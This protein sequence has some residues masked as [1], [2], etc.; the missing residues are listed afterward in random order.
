[1]TARRLNLKISRKLLLAF[2]VV[3]ATVGISNTVVFMANQSVDAATLEAKLSNDQL[4]LEAGVLASAVDVQNSMRGFI[5]S[6]DAKSFLDAKV[7]FY[8]KLKTLDTAYQSLADMATDEDDRA[9]LAPVHD[10]IETFKSEADAAIQMG[11]N[12]ETLNTARAEISGTARLLK[13]REAMSAMSGHEKEQLA[14]FESH[15]ADEVNKSYMVLGAGALLA[16]LISALMGWWLTRGIAKPVIQ[17]TD[18]MRRLAK[19]DNSIAIPAKGQ[20]DE[21][22]EMA[23]ALDVFKQAAIE[24]EALEAV[25]KKAAA[26]QALV[27]GTLSRGLSDLSKGILTAR[28]DVE[29]SPEYRK[30]RDDFNAAVM[31]LQDAMKVIIANVQGIRSGA[32]EIS[33]AADDLSRRTEQQAASLE[34]TAAALDEITATVS[35]TADGARQANAVVARSQDRSRALGRGCPQGGRR[36]GRD[37]GVLAQDRADHRRHRRDRLPD[38]PPGAQRRCRS[39]AGRRSRPRLCGRRLRSARAGPAVVGRRQ[40]DQDADPRLI[41]AGRKRRRAGQP[42]RRSAPADR[43]QGRRDLEPGLRNLRLDPG[44]VHRPRAGQHGR[45]PDGP[46]DPAERGDGRGINRRLALARPGSRRTLRARLEVRHRCS[47]P[48]RAR[49]AQAATQTPGRAC[50]PDGSVS[51]AADAGQCRAQALGRSR[52]RQ[53][54]RLLETSK[55]TTGRE[56]VLDVINSRLSLGARLGL[57]SALFLAPT[58]LLATLFV[59][60]T[61]SQ[62]SF[63]EKEIQGSEY[64]VDLWPSLVAS[65]KDVASA[66]HGEF[67]AAFGTGAA[68]NA[69]AGSKGAAR[70]SAGATLFSDVADAA[71]LTLDTELDSFYAMDAATMR[72]PALLRAVADVDVAIKDA[73][74]V[75]GVVDEQG[76]SS[77][78]V[79]SAIERT[80]EASRVAIEAL[81]GAMKSNAAGD[82][83]RALG[84]GVTT[85]SG[86]VTPLANAESNADAARHAVAVANQV[87]VV[88]RAT[89]AE[90]HRLI[91]ARI[92]KLRGEQFVNLGIVALTVILAALLAFI[93]VTGLSGRFR[94]LLSAMDGLTANQLDTDIPCRED[95][96]ETGRIAQALDVFK[97]G[98]QERAAPRGENQGCSRRAGHGGRNARLEALAALARQPDLPHRAGLPG[99]VPDPAP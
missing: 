23:D 22:G 46:G 63:A 75:T 67:D 86:L 9:L 10:A 58:V 42:H 77:A 47:R 20:G 82:T 12:P 17:M 15:A 36:H 68:F 66:R 34:E 85:L 83:R 18:A 6:G 41:T 48:E 27:V 52:R 21:I 45:Q 51:S 59:N 40:G 64:L 73:S 43:D 55:N 65:D 93:I 28:F 71:N 60:T 39:G 90:M 33:H 80:G 81:E 7:G 19:G 50:A 16:I 35:K 37:R 2:G 26:E 89:S 57:L 95:R 5:A 24:K 13:L 79:I 38:Q 76:L 3:V 11:R 96:N 61:S 98:L 49:R 56:I 25:A 87:D 30:V 32:D 84:E 44:A 54:G 31:Q 70:V 53:L 94:K 14:G 29:V 99:R 74:A 78:D 8:E 88:W 4:N 72:L 92:D 91:Q 62:I 97:R 1:M 69:F